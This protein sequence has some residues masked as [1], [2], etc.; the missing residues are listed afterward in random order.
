MAHKVKINGTNYEV[1]GGRTLIGATG[2]D[3]SDGNTKIAA[4]GY[5]VGFK[6]YTGVIWDG[7]RIDPMLAF[8]LNVYGAYNSSTQTYT[9]SRT[10]I[11]EPPSDAYWGGSGVFNFS[12]ELALAGVVSTSYLLACLIVPVNTKWTT[13]DFTI[14]GQGNAAQLMYWI[15]DWTKIDLNNY[16]TPIYLRNNS[17]TINQ[18]L[19]RTDVKITYYPYPGYPV[20]ATKSE[21]FSDGYFVFMNNNSNN[22]SPN[23][24]YSGMS[25]N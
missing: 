25:L 3:V 15:D 12:G 20:T 18:P 10:I 4:T 14:T 22:Q 7:N 23:T 19:I 13:L 5:D 8:G 16:G 1:T 11:T 6:Y 24:L 17:T 9:V 2:Y 21:S